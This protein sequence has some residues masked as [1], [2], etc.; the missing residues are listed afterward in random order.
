MTVRQFPEVPKRWVRDDPRQSNEHLF[1]VAL[2]VRGLMV[3]QSN[4]L[5]EL[6]LAA[7][8]TSTIVTNAGIG[9]TS[10]AFLTPLSATAAAATGIWVETSVGAFTVHHN[11]DP[12]TDRSFCLVFH[13]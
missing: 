2:A 11:S 4:N 6:T 5:I 1:V 7:G 9:I 10:R 13:G 12:A 8:A 3:G